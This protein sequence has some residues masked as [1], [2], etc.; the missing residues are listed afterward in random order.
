MTDRERERIK[1]HAAM[2]EMERED[3]VTLQKETVRALQTHSTAFFNRVYSEDFL[4]T[5]AAGANV[6][7][8]TYVLAVQN[9]S[10]Q[11]SSFIATDISVRVFENTAVTMCLWSARGTY[12]GA[13]FARQSRVT[14]VYVYGQRG[15]QVVASHET[16]LPG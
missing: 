16:Q 5:S 3:L 15:W 10:S 4:G 2:A 11:Y 12:R 8:A 7:K 1:A 14:T 9:N 6:N 13:P